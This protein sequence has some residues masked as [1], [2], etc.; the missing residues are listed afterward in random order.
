MEPSGPP[1]VLAETGL[2]AIVRDHFRE[3]LSE[4]RG[5]FPDHADA[6]PGC[7][8]RRDAIGNRPRSRCRPMNPIFSKWLTG[9]S[10]TVAGSPI[11]S[12]MVMRYCAMMRRSDL[13]TDPR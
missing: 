9:T 1:T 3:S 7:K 2:M 8:R 6:I 10:L 11:Y 5:R 12:S 13:L 4:P